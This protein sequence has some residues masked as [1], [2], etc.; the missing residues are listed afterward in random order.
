MK[1][2]CIIIDDEQ[3]ARHGLAADIAALDLLTVSGTAADTREALQLLQNQPI[4]VL[5]LDIEMPGISGLEF[6]PGLPGKPLV[7]LVTAYPQYALKG[8]EHGVVDYLLKPVSR[9]RLR[10]ACEKVLEWYA[11]RHPDEKYLYLKC[12]G[13]L[14]KVAVPDILFIEA[15]NNYIQVYIAAKKMLVYQTLKG[16]EQQLPAGSFV[17]VHKSFLVATRHISQINGNTLSV[18]AHTIPLSRRFKSQALS[19]LSLKP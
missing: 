3:L 16:I 10:S 8:Y 11:L 18:G 5:F 6:L 9:T 2:R 19:H 7:I 15:A 17:Q 12:N 1:P 14:V 4:D 13:V